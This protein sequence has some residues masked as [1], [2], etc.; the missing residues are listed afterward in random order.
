MD[1]DQ[2]ELVPRDRVID[3]RDITNESD[4]PDLNGATPETGWRM[5]WVGIKNADIAVEKEQLRIKDGKEYMTHWDHVMT[6][7][8]TC[9]HAMQVIA[10]HMN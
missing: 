5:K 3:N 2:L 4:G 6:Y 7:P 1:R 9:E 8:K 10:T